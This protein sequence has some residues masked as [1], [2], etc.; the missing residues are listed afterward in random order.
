MNIISPY[1]T[2]TNISFFRHTHIHA[3]HTDSDA[4]LPDDADPLDN[5]DEYELW[6]LREMTRLKRDAEQREMSALEKADLMRRRNLTE[7]ERLA[8]DNAAGRF[9]VKEKKKLN[10]MQKYY[11]KGAFFMDEDSIKNPNDV[12]TRDYNEP[13]LEDKIDKQKL[14]EVMQVKNFGKRG[15][16]KYTHLADQD[17][18]A[19]GEVGSIMGMKS[20][21]GLV[22]KFSSRMAGVGDLDSA[23]RLHKKPKS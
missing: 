9:D 18:Y 6:T 20:D 5:D 19:K 4:G 15:R 2:H 3:H 11:H 10:F 22:D 13:T 21:R 12:R 17:T 14:P 23:G 16:T 1:L 8:E 7:E